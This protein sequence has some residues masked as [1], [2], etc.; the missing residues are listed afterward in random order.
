[1]WLDLVFYIV[2]LSQI[3]LIS[4]YYPQKVLKR[5]TYILE[6]CPP[7]QYPKLYENDY[8]VNPTAV[9][10]KVLSLYKVWNTGIGVVGIILLGTMLFTGYSPQQIKENEHLLFVVVFTFVQMVPYIYIELSSSRWYA[11]VRAAAVNKKRSAEL[12][13]R[14]LFDFVSPSLVA[15]AVFLFIASLAFYIYSHSDISPWRWNQYM[16]VFGMS[17]VNLAFAVTIVMAING[18]KIDPHQSHQDLMKRLRTIVQIHVFTSIG[19][20]LFLITMNLVNQFKLDKFEP[21]FL[22]VYFQLIIMIGIG[23]MMRTLSVDAVDFEAY[24]AEPT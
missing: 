13:P 19:M 5:S 23:Q 24:R 16:T 21:L 17:A 6:T 18:K 14:K 11:H 10:K 1:M 4:F 20:S 15:L 8:Y 9:F 2:L 12:S 3:A 22:S 7:E